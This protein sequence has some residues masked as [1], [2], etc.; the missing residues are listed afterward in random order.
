[1]SFAVSPQVLLGVR[2]LRSPSVASP[3]ELSTPTPSPPTTTNHR[4]PAGTAVQLSGFAIPQLDPEIVYADTW[5]RG[6]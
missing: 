3:H 6:P 1:M 5:S 2:P 4:L